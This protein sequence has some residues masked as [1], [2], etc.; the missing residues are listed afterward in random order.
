MAKILFAL[1]HGERADKAT[2]TRR[3]Y[4]VRDDPCLT[5]IGLDQAEIAANVIINS[6]DLTMN[7][8]LVSS[9]FLRCIETASKIAQRL[10]I[11]I[12][13]EEGF[14]ELLE[15]DIFD[16]ETLNNLYFHR[17]LEKI[18]NDLQVSII[19]NTHVTRPIYPESYS[20]G[21]RRVKYAWEQYL[22][23]CNNYD[24]IIIVSHLFVVDELSALWGDKNSLY[25]MG[26]CKLTV[27]KHDGTYSI[28][29]NSTS[30][31]I[32]QY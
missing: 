14:A 20:S 8:H 23:K 21:G 16:S 3:K 11:P 12:H 28:I 6:L 18:R 4:K 27:A 22:P 1:R 17:K 25:D 2:T 29:Q 31:Y 13:L 10:N 26:Y 32:N 7:V 24:A 5:E 19:E 9:P 15:H 30:K